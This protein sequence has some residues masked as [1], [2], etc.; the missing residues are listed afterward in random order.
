MRRGSGSVCDRE[1]E[2]EHE[3]E[4]ETAREGRR[5]RER[6]G[7][8]AGREGAKGTGG[9]GPDQGATLA[10]AG[11]ASPLPP[12]AP[13]SLPSPAAAFGEAATYSL[14]RRMA[15]W[16]GVVSLALRGGLLA[17]VR[18]PEAYGARPA[19]I[20]RA[21]GSGA[22]EGEATR[23]EKIPRSR[24]PRLPPALLDP[25]RGARALRRTGSVRRCRS[26]PSRGRKGA[27]F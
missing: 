20:L 13:P 22:G 7:P 12:R 8:S 19:R 27:C 17:A 11:P 6:G 23:P 14:V 9:G 21:G 25:R 18:A 3:S 2:R 16:L 24:W 1:K 15:G 26:S 10:P 4:G 5:V